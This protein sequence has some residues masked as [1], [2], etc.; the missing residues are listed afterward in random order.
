MMATTTIA[1]STCLAAYSNNKKPTS[2]SHQPPNNSQK[3][4]AQPCTRFFLFFFKIMSA[5]TSRPLV[6]LL[7]RP[8]PTRPRSDKVPPGKVLLHQAAEDRAYARVW[9]WAS[10]RSSNAPTPSAR[11]PEGAAT[12]SS[13]EC[14][15][16]PTRS[17]FPVTQAL[18]TIIQG[19]REPPC[20]TTAAHI[21][22][23]DGVTTGTTVRRIVVTPSLWY[24]CSVCFWRNGQCSDLPPWNWAITCSHAK[25]KR[26]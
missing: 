1:N 2:N 20:A 4:T 6:P 14:P 26:K 11:P 21:L 12:T 5:L 15:G 7:R 10:E 13:S 16:L 8:D 9:P 23:G 19:Q 24:C 22:R 18:S 3:S 25:N 17:R